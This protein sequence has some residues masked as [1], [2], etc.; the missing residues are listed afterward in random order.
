[1]FQGTL[2]TY[3]QVACKDRTAECAEC[4]LSAEGAPRD[5][6]GAQDPGGVVSTSLWQGSQER[7]GLEDMTIIFTLLAPL[8][9]ILGTA[10]PGL[11]VFQGSHGACW[12]VRRWMVEPAGQGCGAE[13]SLSA[14]RELGAPD[15]AGPRPT[16]LK[17]RFSLRVAVQRGEDV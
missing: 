2:C 17:P 14:Q 13:W 8:G 12:P 4:P 1:M 9:L 10:L 16:G 7:L 15:P 5:P 6:L 3:E 11:W